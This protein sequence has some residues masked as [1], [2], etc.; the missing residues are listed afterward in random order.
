MNFTC[1]FKR[2]VKSMVSREGVRK[3][4]ADLY[5]VVLKEALVTLQGP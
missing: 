4:K 3:R 5:G 2:D 1:T